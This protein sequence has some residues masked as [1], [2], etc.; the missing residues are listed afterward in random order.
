MPLEPS[1][2]RRVAGGDG[3]RRGWV[4][5]AAESVAVVPS[6]AA[7]MARG[8]DVVGVDMPIGLPDRWFR[9]ADR[10]ARHFLGP[11]RWSVFPVPPRELLDATS[12]DEANITSRAR[13]GQG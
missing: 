11:R 6:F 9:A 3:C 7:V 4:V 1:A 12:W 2:G 5:A 13:Y 8:S 10:E